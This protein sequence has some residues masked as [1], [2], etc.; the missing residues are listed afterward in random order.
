MANKNSY[1]SKIAL[2]IMVVL[3]LIF[4]FFAY[5]NQG[6]NFWLT[7]AGGIATGALMASAQYFV[8]MMEYKEIDE[9]YK[10][11]HQKE[12]EI[13]SF[14]QMG[15]KRVLPARDNPDK[16]GEFI[17]IAKDRL[18]VMGNTASRLMDDFAN[19]DDSSS[20]LWYR[21]V[22]IE[23]LKNGVDV[24]ILVAARRYLPKD[25]KP[26]Y[27][28]AKLIFEKLDKEYENFNFAYFNH[29]PTHSIF[30]F[31]D[32]CLLGPIFDNLKS[33]STP[34]LHMDIESL[35]AQKYINYFNHKWIEATNKN[36]N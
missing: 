2:F 15:V 8:S 17:K 6:N 19:D 1:I 35:Y 25:E 22:L 9:A 27:D 21:S 14:I 36:E 29:I 31:D 20:E 34:A 13:E 12:K 33:S 3:A 7:I 10:K 4:I 26:K 24:K 18:W 23:A 16:Y 30:V 5:K 32:D 11:L 28:K